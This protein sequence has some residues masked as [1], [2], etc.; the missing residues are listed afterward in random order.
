MIPS[1]DHRDR[2]L[3]AL[4][5]LIKH[6]YV[7]QLQTFIWL[8]ISRKIK[9]KVEEDIENENLAKKKKSKRMGPCRART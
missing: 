3:Q 4:G 1:K 7:T 6:G 5:W 2:Y 9:I 8:K